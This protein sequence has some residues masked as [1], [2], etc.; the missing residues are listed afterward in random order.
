M[1]P[2]RYQVTHST[3]YGYSDVVTSSYG[4]GYLTPRDTARQHCLAHS[5][6]SI[7]N[8]GQFHQPRRVRKRQLLFPCDGTASQAFGNQRV[9]RGGPTQCRRELYGAGSAL[10]PWEIADPSA[11][12][13]RWHGVHA[14]P[15]APGDHDDVRAYAAA[16]FEPGKR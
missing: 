6:I 12:T 16:S 4:R 3:I 9:R 10:A 5:L 8:D 7:P 14:R 15:A 2:R 13:R 11:P 1:S